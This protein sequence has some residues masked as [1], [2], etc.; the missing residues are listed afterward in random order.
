V[1]FADEGSASLTC[2]T[3]DRKGNGLYATKLI[4]ILPVLTR[5]L[6]C[7]RLVLS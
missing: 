6:V 2:V 1:F 7:L 4:G 5:I 3:P